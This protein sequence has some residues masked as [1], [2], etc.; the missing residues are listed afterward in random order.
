MKYFY[1][2]RYLLSLLLIFSTPS[3]M[4]Q[5]I[6]KIQSSQ[7][8]ES[9][10]YK[11]IKFDTEQDPASVS[12]VQQVFKTYLE[13]KK[14]DEL[15]VSQ[16]SAD[17]LGY[18]H[19]R[20]QQYY[21]GVKVEFGTYLV[22]S[23]NGRVESMNGDY[24]KIENLSID[25]SIS[26]D[27]ALNKAISDIG[28][29][30][31]LWQDEQ[32][33]KMIDYKKPQGELV[34]VEGRL[35]YKF[36]IYAVKPLSRANVYVDANNG[37]V[38]LKNALIYHADAVGTAATRYSGSRSI[39]ADS[40]SGSYRLRDYSRGL[41]IETYD[42]N[43]GINYNSA[44]DFVDNDN[45]WT[46]GEWNNTN[47]D[48]AAL[49][50]HFGAEMTYDYF[51]TTFN[52]NSYDN[53]GAK[54]KSYVH[55]DLV[56][57]GYP[58]NDNAF[59]DGSRM[60]YGDGTS[61]DPLTTLDIAAH[62]IGHA[63]CS[64]S[65]NLVYSN[66]SGAM[67][68]GFSDIWAAS[69]EYFAAPEKNTWV[70]GEDLGTVV[71]S[72]ENPKAAGQPD[73]Y[74]GT[75]WYSGT[76]D[77]GGV[78]TNS[79]VLNH[80]FYILSVGKTGTNDIGT[81]YS[82]TGIGINKAAAVAYRLETVYLSSN[83]T[84]AD[85]QS[86]GIQ[87]AVDLYGAGSAEAIATQ[88]AWNAVGIGSKY[89]EISYCASNG[90]SV[91]DEYIG[92]VQLGSI[93]NATSGSAGGYGDY[94]SISTDLTKGASATITITP[95]WTGSKYNE[96]Y[97]VWID[98]NQDGDF[99]DAGEQVWTKAAS[100]TTPVSGSFTVPSSAADGVTRMRVSMKYNGIPTACE[101]FSYG[102]V[103]DYAINI[104]ASTGDTQAP[105]TPT[106]L[107]A[108]S[109]TQTSASLSWTAS[110][111]NVG[112]TG[113]NVYK[114]GVLDG[115]S[116]GTTYALTGLSAGTT[117]AITV[118]A[119]D[120][121][122]NLSGAAS[123]N[124]T[125][126]SAGMSCSS[127]V[128][129]PYSEGFESGFGAWTQASGD[130]L[131]WSRRSGSTPSSST[132]PSAASQGSY[133]IY[134]EA[135]SPNYP[136]KTTMI[137]SPCFD[138]TGET[139]A[140][141]TFKYHMYGASMG[142]LSLQATTNGSTW[143]TVWTMTGNKGNS[144]LSA[145]VDL[146]AYAGAPVK[147]RYVGTTGSSYTGDMALDDLAMT[148]GGGS[149]S[150][151]V[152][153]TLTFDNY[154][155]ETSWQIKSGSTVVASGGTYGSQPDGS[156]INVNVTLPDGCYDFVISDTYGDGIC[157]SYGNGSYTLKAGTTVLASGSSFASSQTTNF[158]VGGASMNGFTAAGVVTS[159]GVRPD[160]F[161]VYPN[162]S[163]G[164]LNLFTGKM[165]AANYSIV[166]AA[167]KVWKAGTLS[168]NQGTIDIHEL[169]AGF[170]FLKVTDGQNVVVQ[171]VIKQ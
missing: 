26:R 171:K 61:L 41:G 129:A 33:A 116:T 108:S 136:S 88:N 112:V 11:Q 18:V 133:Y 97:S 58:N 132:G 22:H 90:N 169:R 81:S 124:V 137:E 157:C 13:T 77:N 5:K 12:E 154:P 148:T 151:D 102:E 19:D 95:T 25:P 8:S 69:V 105:T 49:D 138:L 66:E 140:N 35:A 167:G 118:K 125:T 56:E 161:S 3:L 107:S 149:G 115:S 128:T 131:D 162:P 134:V 21:K 93:N 76:A 30:K 72:L 158:C 45:N 100:Q 20:Y 6:G 139:G 110:T 142:T 74:K 10:V 79:G 144:W 92:R 14:D 71:R 80:W 23:K 165:G 2:W 86:Y 155:E 28:A 54:I 84:Y 164:I 119:K 83:S 46:A 113:Y 114:A 89:G 9:G 29:S 62:E 127:T 96:G 103:E 15:K 111:D 130:D 24:K 120:A 16:T 63:V 94:T 99:S 36:D 82:V 64:N 59:W 4:A 135:S 53:A 52:R 68:E 75:N 51:F 31:Y 70:L 47:K 60:T 121:A 57:Y 91:S 163:N 104:G 37:K 123:L 39:H 106:N 170:Y 7:R 141:F 168:G 27:E 85:A 98:Y 101:S 153:L 156:T 1:N 50:A 67:N 109:I 65:A 44:V 38:L 117:Y 143:S 34:I 32:E 146:S 43:M 159:E 42:M 126:Q 166:N 48:N 160:G 78:H 55:F 87:A 122:G 150:T 17:K 73:T 145:N 40:Y 152:T 147:L